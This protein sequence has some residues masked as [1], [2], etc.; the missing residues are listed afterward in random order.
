MTFMKANLVTG[1]AGN[2]VPVGSESSLKLHIQSFF[3]ISRNVSVKWTLTQANGSI[4]SGESNFSINAG[5]SADVVIPIIGQA[6]G[7]RWMDYT[8]TWSSGQVKDRAGFVYTRAIAGQVRDQTGFELGFNPGYLSV[9]ADYPAMQI[10]GVTSIRTKFDWQFIEFPNNNYNWCVPDE[11]VSLAEKY[12]MRIMW[13]CAYGNIFATQAGVYLNP[14]VGPPISTHWIDFLYT[15]TKRYKGRITWYEIWSKPN[16]PFFFEGNSNDYLRILKDG[17]NAIKTAYPQALVSTGGFADEN[18]TG[19]GIN[20][21]IERRTL[22]EASQY[23]DIHAFHARDTLAAQ[24]ASIAVFTPWRGDMKCRRPLWMTEAGMH[25]AGAVFTPSIWLDQ[26]RETVKKFVAAR[27]VGMIGY[28][29]ADAVDLGLDLFIPDINFGIMTLF[30]QPKPS[31]G[32]LNEAVNR[33]RHYCYYG[34]ISVVP[35]TCRLYI[36]KGPRGYLTVFW[37]QSGSPTG[38]V[39]EV[40]KDPTAWDMWGNSI[41]MGLSGTLMT[42]A[43]DVLPR[44]IESVKP[45][46]IPGPAAQPCIPPPPDDIICDISITTGPANTGHVNALAPFAR[47]R[48]RERTVNGS[49]QVTSFNDLYRVGHQ[50]L[51]VDANR[52][53][54]PTQRKNLAYRDVCSFTGLQQY[55]SNLTAAQWKFL[56]SSTPHEIFIVLLSKVTASTNPI[57]ATISGTLSNGWK[58]SAALSSGIIT[59]SVYGTVGQVLNTTSSVLT[60]GNAVFIRIRSNLALGPQE[61]MTTFDSST[62]GQYYGF[63]PTTTNPAIPLTFGDGSGN[64]FELAEFIVFDRALSDIERDVVI[65]YIVNWYDL[66][67]LSDLVNTYNP[68]SRTRAFERV[69]SGGR[70]TQFTDLVRIGHSMSQATPANQVL[71][72]QRSALLNDREMAQFTLN[73]QYASNI[74]ASLWNFLHKDHEREV[75]IVLITTINGVQNTIL[76]S[77]ADRLSNGMTLFQKITGELVF[78]VGA[79]AGQRNDISTIPLANNLPIVANL[80]GDI[81]AN[82]PN[83]FRLALNSLDDIQVPEYMYPP[84]QVDTGQT[85]LLGDLTSDSFKFA[86]FLI[87]DRKLTPLE[88]QNVRRY[89]AAWYGIAAPVVKFTSWTGSGTMNPKVIAKGTPTQIAGGVHKAKGNMKVDIKLIPKGRKVSYAKGLI[90]IKIK[91]EGVIKKAPGIS[92]A[93]ALSSRRV[94]LEFDSRMV[95]DSILKNALNYQ[96]SPV[97]EGGVEVF[98]KQVIVPVGGYPLYIDLDV[99]EMTNAALYTVSVTRNFGSPVDQYGLKLSLGRLSTN[100]IGKGDAPIVRYIASIGPNRIDVTFSKVMLNEDSIRNPQKYQWTDGLQTISVLGVVSNVVQLVTTD[101]IPGHKYQLTISG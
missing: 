49:N 22:Q 14:F 53:S 99:S 19:A 1:N 36:F 58:L 50:W 48:C 73:H 8:V 21:S 91:L 40:G 45:P 4:S 100:F 72:L 26:A 79:Q 84:T 95:P 30:R 11:Q 44:Y 42:I 85:L 10:I 39:V 87:F 94:R 64:G 96:I 17:Y 92:S 37:K 80:K 90:P 63:T 51:P 68:F 78:G 62:D 28:T 59:S 43:F 74:A 55:R 6:L 61:S 56:H 97:F 71:A 16:V 41:G 3:V 54:G 25:T 47:L 75:F 24:E 67:N 27:A 32:A 15:L 77:S 70:V 46:T 81:A 7:H 101:Q 60:N 66:L 69:E 23:Y 18:I 93:F 38:L 33:T 88:R 86:E 13:T 35:G 2:L 31:Y 9:E 76:T 83:V 12:H 34:T 57:A 89:V 82:T 52:V 98:V 29:I 20:Q 65:D 5:G